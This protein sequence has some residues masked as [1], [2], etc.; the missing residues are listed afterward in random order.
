MKKYDCSVPK[1]KK[2]ASGTKLTSTLS[3]V[4]NAVR[5]GEWRVVT[6]DARGDIQLDARRWHVIIAINTTGM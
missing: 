6:V 4:N 5:A 3:I 1:K 2:K